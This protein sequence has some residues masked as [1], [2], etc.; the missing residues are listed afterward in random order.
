MKPVDKC[1]YISK[2]KS[3]ERP[4][5][6]LRS[7]ETNGKPD[8]QNIL[9]GYVPMVLMKMF[10]PTIFADLRVRADIE[11][12]EWIIEREVKEGWKEW[13]RIPGQLDSDFDEPEN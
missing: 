2:D 10:G 8:N 4:E 13:V 5:I 3:R 1:L 7:T 9:C 6:T 12:C 11:T